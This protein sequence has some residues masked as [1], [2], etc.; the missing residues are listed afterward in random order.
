MDVKVYRAEKLQ[1]AMSQIRKDL[2]A[3]AVI[4]NSR[5]KTIEKNGIKRCLYEVTAVPSRLKSTLQAH[6]VQFPFIQNPGDESMS[7][8]KPSWSSH[9]KID[10]LD[11]ASD[12]VK[13]VLSELKKLQADLSSYRQELQKPLLA[14]DLTWIR[15]LFLNSIYP[16][17]AQSEFPYLSQLRAKGCF[18]DVCLTLANELKRLPSELD[19]SEQLIN[20]LFQCFEARESFEV[21]LK[22]RKEPLILAFHGPAGAGKSTFLSKLMAKFLQKFPQKRLGLGVLN[23]VK[24]AA[25]EPLESFS[26]LLGSELFIF[27]SLSELEKFSDPLPVDIF[28]LECPSIESDQMLIRELK[29]LSCPYVEHVLLLNCQWHESYSLQ[30]L[31][32]Y[33]HYLPSLQGVSFSKLDEFDLPG[34]IFSFSFMAQA[35]VLYFNYGRSLEDPFFLCQKKDLLKKLWETKA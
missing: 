15:Q 22:K 16:H 23:R 31:E 34:A 17:L 25:H 29:D 30:C 19:S 11:N 7:L 26:H 32:R 35:P 24:V 4:L 9:E 27:R 21:D 1:T 6:P 12:G 5:T 14:T 3:N 13:G 20:L 28:L 2:G 10:L 18:T 8:E 33:S